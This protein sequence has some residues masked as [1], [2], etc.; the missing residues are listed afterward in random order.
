MTRNEKLEF[1]KRNVEGGEYIADI[2]SEVED[3]IW[4]LKD[5]VIINQ[6]LTEWDSIDD[7]TLEVVY[8][9][10]KNEYGWK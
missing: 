6:K 2:A 10:M 9:A 7:A 4:L 1:M 8:D 5:G 3:I